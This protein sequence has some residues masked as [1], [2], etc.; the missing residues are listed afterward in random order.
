MD[1]KGFISIEYLFLIFIVL[2]IAV[3]L[4]FFTSASI[5]STN[6]I[7]DNVEHRLILDYVAN[8][9]NQVNAN[10]EGYSIWIYLDSKPGF[11][12]IDV[13]KNKLTIEFSN[14]KGETLVLTLKIESK[15]KWYSGR[16]YL[17]SKNDDG[18]IVIK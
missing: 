8:M 4:L 2:I 6:N 14:K 11:Y 1:K 13:E 7:A 5:G 15:Y 3:G 16:S 10:G 9:I 12:E 17:I 18:E